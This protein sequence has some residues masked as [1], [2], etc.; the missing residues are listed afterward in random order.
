MET[1]DEKNN[2]IEHLMVTNPNWQEAN[3]LVI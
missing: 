2:A 1:N 3:K